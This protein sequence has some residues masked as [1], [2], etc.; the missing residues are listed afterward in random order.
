MKYYYGNSVKEALSNP[1]VEI[2]TTK[3]LKQY[4]ENYNVVIECEAVP[5]TEVE[6]EIDSCLA[7]SLE[8][9]DYLGSKSRVVKEYRVLRGNSGSFLSCSVI[10]V[11]CLDVC[12][13]LL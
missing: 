12:E 7:D 10:F 4:E 13:D 9:T 1:P 6:M 3:Q 11:A 5:P 2:K 8:D